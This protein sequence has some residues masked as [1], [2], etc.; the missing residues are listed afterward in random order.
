ME[1]QK[2][3]IGTMIGTLA[4]K[5]PNEVYGAM[6]GLSGGLKAGALL[7]LVKG[8]AW[9]PNPM[10]SLALGAGSGALLGGIG[11]AAFGRALTNMATRFPAA[12][13]PVSVPIAPKL[14]PGAVARLMMLR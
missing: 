10:E 12:M 9:D 4:Q 3:A 2:I 13:A 14:M 7:G 1:I 5:H 8:L 6:A 11:G